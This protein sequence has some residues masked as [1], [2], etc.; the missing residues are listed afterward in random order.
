M[1]TSTIVLAIS[2]VAAL[3]VHEYALG[4]AAAAA[5]QPTTMS[6]I[7]VTAPAQKSFRTLRLAEAAAVRGTYAMSNGWVVKVRPDRRTVFAEIDRRGM[8][9][10]RPVS[11]DKFTTLDGSMTMQ[12]NLGDDGNDMLLGYRPDPAL[13]QMVYVGTALA[14]R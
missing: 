3:A 8:M 13:A 12:F 14:A 9:E 1:R 2:T 11:A 5:P 7:R 4:Q 10:L 6:E